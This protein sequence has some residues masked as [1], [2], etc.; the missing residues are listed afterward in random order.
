MHPNGPGDA[1]TGA[2][3][4]TRELATTMVVMEERSC[5]ASYVN[6]AANSASKT[7]T[8]LPTVGRD[9]ERAF[10]RTA[11][12]GRGRHRFLLQRAPFRWH[13]QPPR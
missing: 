12:P 11:G 13:S 6:A 7:G 2:P 8:T 9:R 10:E 4:G 3:A 5:N 1:V